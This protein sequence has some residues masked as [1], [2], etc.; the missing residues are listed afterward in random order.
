MGMYNTVKSE[1]EP[2]GI[3]KF[4]TKDDP[5]GD[6][7]QLSLREQ[8]IDADGQLWDD[9]GEVVPNPS[10]KK[11][12]GTLE[13]QRVTAFTYPSHTWEKKMVKV[14]ETFTMYLWPHEGRLERRVD[15]VNGVIVG[16]VEFL[17]F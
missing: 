2:I 10:Y 1:Y 5:S 3:G 4:Q 9:L 13:E 17:P 16:E 11:P 12:T 15:F 14:T 8:V 7:H 6:D